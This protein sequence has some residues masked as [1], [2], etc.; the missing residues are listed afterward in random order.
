MKL[1]CFFVLILSFVACQ[2]KPPVSP[3]TAGNEQLQL[4]AHKTEAEP[5]HATEATSLKGKVIER[6]DAGRYSYLRLSTSSGEIWAAVPK[7]AVKAGAEVTILNQMS[8]DGFETP[9]LNRKFDRLVFGTL[10][11]EMQPSGEMQALHDAHASVSGTID[12]GPIKVEKA[13]D[14]EGRTIAE[15]FAQKAKLKD[16]AVAVRGKVVKVNARIMGK[17]WIH[18]RD[19]SGNRESK[20][21]DLTVTTQGDAAVGDTVVVKGIVRTDKNFG[22]GY[23]FPVIIE[24][25]TVIKE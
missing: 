18:L 23:V 14:P 13:A 25:A 9:T 2:S 3:D 21:D 19:G 12:P 1:S 10:D 5:H 7:T 8:M 20:T 22:I 4:S 17:T 15:I 6:L 24:D 11:Q 16:R